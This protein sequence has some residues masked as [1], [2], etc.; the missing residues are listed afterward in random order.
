M[1]TTKPFQTLRLFWLAM[2]CENLSVIA[3]MDYLIICQRSIERNQ[4]FWFYDYSC[5]DPLQA[6]MKQNIP[7][8]KSDIETQK[9]KKQ[10]KN[11][12]VMHLTETNK[13]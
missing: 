11:N 5:S 7:I 1:K 4:F 13:S 6:K 10:R 9:F 8:I 3:C 2:F 12:S